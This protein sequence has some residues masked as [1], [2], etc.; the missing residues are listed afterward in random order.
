MEDEANR[1]AKEDAGGKEGRVMRDWITSR[2][3]GC[4]HALG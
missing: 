1:V 4:L 3:S 2:C